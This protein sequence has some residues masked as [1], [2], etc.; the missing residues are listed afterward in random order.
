MARPKAGRPNRGYY[1]TGAKG[2]AQYRKDVQKYNEDL[3]KAKEA[4]TKLSTEKQIKKQTEA[5][6]KSANKSKTS[7]SKTKQPRSSAAKG[8]SLASGK[9]TSKTKATDNLQKQ[10]EVKKR[11]RPTKVVETPNKAKSAPKNNNLKIVKDAAKSTYKGV[12]KIAGKIGGKIGETKGK[13]SKA[14]DKPSPTKRPTNRLQKLA[15]KGNKA[16]KASSKYVRGPL[17]EHV[18]K[19]GGKIIQGIKKDPRSLGKGAKG[20]AALVAGEALINAAGRRIAKSTTKRARDQSWK[21]FNKDWSRIHQERRTLPTAKRT[22]K[23]IGNVL[24]GRKYTHNN[25][26]RAQELN[27]EKQAS[28]KKEN[29][30]QSSSPKKSLYAKYGDRLKNISDK[31]KNRNKKT[32]K[33]T[34]N[35]E[36][37]TSKDL[38]INKSSDY[39][40]NKKTH[41][42][43]SEGGKYVKAPKKKKM[44]AIEKRNRERFGDA[45]VD[46]LKEQYKSFKASRGDKEKRKKHKEKYGVR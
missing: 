28:K 29:K 2:D 30:N 10:P 8:K 21:E 7:A 20:G 37:S 19:K 46:R 14:F 31:F 34:K 1:A 12:K 17:K 39:L 26:T 13:I 5:N 25:K 35:N 41:L 36:K 15:S 24:T 6:K 4:K 9:K 3:K 38:K 11:G 16:L 23:G 42:P 40:D 22:L 33:P 18:L 44:G 27:E 45:H 43:S 32:D